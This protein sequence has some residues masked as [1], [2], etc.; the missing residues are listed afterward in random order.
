MHADVSVHDW[1][2]HTELTFDLANRTGR[3]QPVEFVLPLPTGAA[4]T[5]LAFTGEAAEPEG[6]LKPIEQAKLEYEA[7]VRKA[8]DPALLEFVGWDSV[9]TSVFPVPVGDGFQVR[10]VYEHALETSS[11]GAMRYVLPRSTL[12]DRNVPFDVRVD[13]ASWEW[14]KGMDVFSPT[15]GVEVAPGMRSSIPN[16]IITLDPSAGVQP[17][18]FELYLRPAE[19]RGAAS[20][21]TASA[22]DEGRFALL[23]FAPPPAESAV[24]MQRDVVVVFDRSGSMRGEKIEQARAGALAVVA[25]LRDGERFN[26]VDYSDT[27]S[28]LWF[29]LR[30]VDAQ[31]REEARA[32]IAGLQ[33]GGGTNFHDALH[34]ALNQCTLAALSI[35]VEVKDYMPDPPARLPLVLALTD[36]L[37]TV[38]E[39]SEAAIRGLATL[40]SLLPT[41]IFA[42]GIGYDVN[43]P[44]LDGL[45]SRSNGASHYVRP[46]QSTEVAMTE[47]FADLEGPRLSDVEVVVLDEAGCPDTSRLVDAYPAR[48]PDLFAGDAL[49]IASRLRGDGPLQVEVRGTAAS[50]P[51]AYRFTFGERAFRRNH[52]FVPRLWATRRIAHLTEQVRDADPELVASGKLTELSDEILRLSTRFGVLSEYSAFLVLEG[53]DLGDWGA[54]VAQNEENCRTNAVDT[55]SGVSQVAQGMNWGSRASASCQNLANDM[56]ALDGS[57]VQVSAVQALG[58]R[59]YVRRPAGEEGAPRWIDGRLIEAGL[60]E[61]ARVV[62]RDTDA[63]ADL[64]GTLAAEGRAACVALSGELLIEVGGEVVLVR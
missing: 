55:R 53:T 48:L 9:R 4:V 18:S 25:G 19:Q 46:G 16:R 8:L 56:V 15:H 13:V 57:R 63:F 39:T 41:R 36:G 49:T 47:V 21:F 11:S 1:V 40:D 27:V 59:A 28:Q 22:G 45:A 32:Y 52:E 23:R 10:V 58:D 54:L 62:A 17:G 31:S 6:G 42:L 38:G 12:L 2:A 37:P 51:V 29:G 14:Q 33:A 7:L 30:E 50:G 43:A 35:Q 20:L 3:P 5:S 64:V 34:T 26:V 44:L 60:P 61:P 24:V